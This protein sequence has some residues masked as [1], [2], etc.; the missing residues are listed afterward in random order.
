MW[1]EGYYD[2]ILR[3][4]DDANAD[5]YGKNRTALAI[6]TDRAVRVPVAASDFVHSLSVTATSG[7]K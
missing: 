2:R 3:P 4:D 5:V 7:R 6:V 1:Q